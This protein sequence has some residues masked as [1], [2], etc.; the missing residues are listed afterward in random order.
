M[1]I[2]T[3]EQLT[4]LRQALAEMGPL[5]F[6]KPQANVAAQAVENWFVASL[7]GLLTAIDTATAPYVFSVPQKRLLVTLWL[8]QKIARGV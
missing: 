5:T 7:A 1:A 8:R 3:P 4:E 6:T 2:L